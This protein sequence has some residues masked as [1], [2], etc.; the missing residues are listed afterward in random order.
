MHTWQVDKIG[1]YIVYYIEHKVSSVINRSSVV[2][3]VGTRIH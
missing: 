2:L 3:M 1:Q